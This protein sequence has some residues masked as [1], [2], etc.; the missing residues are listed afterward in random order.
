MKEP[1]QPT[2]LR[3]WIG[4]DRFAELIGIDLMEVR[5]GWAK[6]R[7]VIDERHLNGFG[8]T[9]GG[10]VFTLA[11]LAFA[12]ASNS[13]G[14]P[15]VAVSVNIFFIKATA[16]GCVLTAEAREISKNPK[17]ATYQ[18]DVHDQNGEIVASF[19]GMVYRKR[20]SKGHPSRPDERR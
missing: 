12:A 6:A 5:P 20:P 13:Y 4:R 8:M 16:S 3:H 9:Q 17:L 19:Q 18:V 2:D 1:E 11:D 7:L 10:T 14:I 15:S